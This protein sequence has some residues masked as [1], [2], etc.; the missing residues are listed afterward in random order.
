PEQLGWNAADTLLLDDLFANGQGAR[1]AGLQAHSAR[2]PRAL[3][4]GQKRS[5]LPWG[6]P[7][8]AILLP[9]PAIR[10]GQQS[11]PACSAHAGVPGG[12]ARATAENREGRGTGTAAAEFDL[13][14]AVVVHVD[15]RR[16]RHVAEPDL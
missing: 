6:V 1:R 9:G 4:R 5:G 7:I 16:C 3:G 10:P 15:R 14:E 13:A 11:R 8:R 2:G 12:G